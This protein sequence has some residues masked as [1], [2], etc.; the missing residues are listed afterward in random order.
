M[1][2][3]SYYDSVVAAL[4]LL[5]LERGSGVIISAL[6]P[7]VY[8]PALESLELRPLLGDVDEVSGTLLPSEAERLK[9]QGG[10][11]F[12][13][14]TPWRHARHG[15]DRGVGDPHHRGS[16]PGG[17][18]FSNDRR[19]GSYGTAVVISLDPT[20]IA[21]AGGG[22]M[23]LLG[24]SGASRALA[25]EADLRPLPDLNASLGLAQIREIEGLIEAR[26]QIAATYAR[27]LKRTRHRTLVQNGDGES[28]HYSFPVMVESGAREV[29]A[30]ARKKGM[31]TRT[32]HE[33]SVLAAVLARLPRRRRC[34]VPPPPAPP[35]CAASCFPFIQHWERRGSERW[36]R[37]DH[38]AVM[39]CECHRVP[40]VCSGRPSA[41]Y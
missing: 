2:L 30:Y 35:S 9:E 39:S 32:A 28:V 24:R 31:E 22:G 4:R 15:C 40:V 18:M 12:L 17:G 7:T 13:L 11:R 27:G 8:L 38:V 6:S 20:A 5:D 21:T 37:S 1:A 10:R 23:V 41:L 25:S 36:S 16:L 34:G 3:A 29:R 26:K 33:G 14:T 19:G